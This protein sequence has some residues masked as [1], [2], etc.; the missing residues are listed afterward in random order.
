MIYCYYRDVVGLPCDF[1]YGDLLTIKVVRYAFAQ[2]VA[3][4]TQ[5]Q[6]SGLWQYLL[7]WVERSGTQHMI[8]RKQKLFKQQNT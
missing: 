3:K 1:F 6:A 7:S 4:A 5:R 8:R 2:R